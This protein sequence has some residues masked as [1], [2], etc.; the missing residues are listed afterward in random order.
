MYLS[1][2]STE[3]VYFDDF[4]VTHEQG[5]LI[6]EDHYYAYGL[7][8]AG[9]SARAFATLDNKNRYQ[10]E[11][12]EHE[13]EWDVHYDDFFLRTYDPQVGRFIN[14][15]PY[16]QFASGYVGMGCDP[17]NS[18]DPSGG[19]VF[20]V[21]NA[22]QQGLVIAGIGAAIGGFV[23]ALTE[24]NG[25]TDPLGRIAKGA[26]IGAGIGATAG[27]LVAGA[28]GL[29]NQF[30]T[31]ELLEKTINI[32]IHHGSKEYDQGAGG[33]LGGHVMI[34]F[35]GEQDVSGFTGWG[36]KK[37]GEPKE[38]P[39][40]PSKNPIDPENWNSEIHGSEA[41]G[42]METLLSGNIVTDEGVKPAGLTTV[43]RINV[44]ETQYLKLENYYQQGKNK[45]PYPYTQFGKRCA[46]SVFKALKKAGVIKVRFFLSSFFNAFNPGALFRFL[47]NKLVPHR[48][49]ENF[50]G[51]EESKEGFNRYGQ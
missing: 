20:G 44:T 51:I 14:I 25:E 16:D 31:G 11:Y 50:R 40:F 12:A 22:F 1:S 30:P 27:V 37:N 4:A 10:G 42:D 41:Y 23:A 3:P 13:D 7:R 19:F 2:E 32:V 5:R 45:S 15:D 26:A 38:V 6:Q 39:L 35:E 49:I 8:I 21:A 24:P 46:S 36:L 9:I 48:T 29:F 43:F 34:N 28:Q 47:K 33:K 18:V 17:V